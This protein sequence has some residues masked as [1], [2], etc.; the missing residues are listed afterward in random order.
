MMLIPF[1]ELAIF[2]LGSLSKQVKVKISWTGY[3]VSYEKRTVFLLVLTLGQRL[4]S[5]STHS[6]RSQPSLSTRKPFLHIIMHCSCSRM[7]VTNVTDSKPEPRVNRPNYG[8]GEFLFF[9]K[10]SCYAQGNVRS[11]ES[12]TQP[13][14]QNLWPIFPSK[15]GACIHSHSSGSVTGEV[16]L[17][18]AFAFEHTSQ[19]LASATEFRFVHD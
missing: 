2:Q 8:D 17:P 6:H 18:H 11:M 4:Y 12:I 5:S 3:R 9:Q 13:G 14:E 10:D 19:F 7:H 15:Q 16:E 1:P